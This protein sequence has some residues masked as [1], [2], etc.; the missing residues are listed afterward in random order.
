MELNDMVN[1]DWA[2]AQFALTIMF[3]FIFVP[4]T[5]GLSFIVAFMHTF[6]YKTKSDF[7]KSVTR[8]WMTLFGVNFAIG[9]ATGLIMEFE[10]GTNWS[11]Y[12]WMVGDIFGAPLAIEGL[13]AFFLEATFFAV[14]FFGWKRVSPR[15]HLIS[16]WM[17]AIGSNLSAFWILVANGW[18][19][20]PVGTKFNPDMGRF[21]MTSFLEVALSPVAMS[22]F[23]HTVS[24]SFV[25][26]A[27]FV[28]GIS[29][30]YIIKNRHL[31][32]AKASIIIATVFGFISSIGVIATGDHGAHYV[33]QTQPMKLAAMEGMFK[34]ER[35]A[36]LTLFG[37]FNHNKKLGDDQ[38]EYFFEIQ[39][40]YLLSFLSYRDFMSFV[41]GIEDLVYGNPKENIMG[42]AEKIDKGKR[43]LR[44][45]DLYRKAKKENNTQE[46]AAQ[47]LIIEENEKYIGYGHLNA[48]EE[49]VPP[50]AIVVHSFHAMVALGS[51][52][53]LLFLVV[54]AVVFTNKCEKFKLLFWISFFSI[55]LGYLAS[56]LGWIVAEVGRQP[57][58]IQD[59][60]PTHKGVT[61]IATMAVQTT[62]WMF[63]VLFVI[64]FAVEMSIMVKQIKLGPDDGS[65]SQGGG[66]HE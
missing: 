29:S 5:L 9:V 38:P 13:F 39:V 55:P 54:F 24:S 50:L 26:S 58:V 27:L 12:S 37:L 16:S 6:Y 10:F 43:G 40:P 36:G 64:L 2:R 51:Y 3:H 33:A 21:E 48:P 1:V 53:V 34:G 28:M 41:P 35:G 46:A 8:F 57:W 47:R 56:Q 19:Q 20:Y 7:W 52:F 63:L 49:I 42:A 15:F 61:H 4:L 44:A 30:W 59:I 66:A 14:M 23:I 65:D 60:L 62:F 25:V 31:K 18:M 11:N 32:M 17:V 22:K 45:L